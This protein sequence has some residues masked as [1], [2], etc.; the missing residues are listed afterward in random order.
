[1]EHP[2]RTGETYRNRDGSYEVEELDGRRLVIRYTDGRRLE[3]TVKLQARIWRNILSE[4][5]IAEQ[6]KPPAPQPETKPHRDRRG[7][8]FTALQD[9]DFQLGVAGTSWRAKT[10][11][12]GLLAREMSAIT[13]YEFE[14]HAVYRQSRVHI[15]RPTFY[16]AEAKWQRAKFYFALNSR[17]AHFGYHVER[18]DGPMDDAW[19]WPG[20]LSVVEAGGALVRRV[21]A[22]MHDL[23]LAWSVWRDA[24]SGLALVARVELTEEGLLSW[25]GAEGEDAKQVTWPAFAARLNRIE[26]TPSAHVFLATGIA[27]H[28]AIAAGVEIVEPVTTVYRALLPLYTASTGKRSP[29][30]SRD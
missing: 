5:P 16:N 20:F 23:G 30:R 13:P 9:H 2:F 19:D 15:A 10:A 6:S 29:G 25:A 21:E 7:R 8:K 3:T 28:E 17:R 4:E 26:P 27:K 14:S 24:A 22:A 18:S 1:M 12:G 11:L